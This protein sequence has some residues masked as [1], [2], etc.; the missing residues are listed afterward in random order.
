MDKMK[1]IQTDHGDT[2]ITH[3][4][5]VGPEPLVR[6]T[7]QLSAGFLLVALI[8]WVL[9]AADS[10]FVRGAAL[11]A[12]IVVTAILSPIGRGVLPSWASGASGPAPQSLPTRSTRD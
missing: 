10:L 6:G 11:V 2:L 4:P 5:D 9:V 12:G 8:V 7:V 3:V 1:T